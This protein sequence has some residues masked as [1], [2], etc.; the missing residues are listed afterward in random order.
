MGVI[1]AKRLSLIDIC[2]CNTA[3][4]RIKLVPVAISQ[5]GSE[6][7]KLVL[8][9]VSLAKPSVGSVISDAKIVQHM[10][11]TSAFVTNV[12]VIAEENTARMSVPRTTMLMKKFTSVLSVHPSVLVDALAP[13]NPSAKLAVTIEYI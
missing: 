3:W 4:Q 7:R 10:A 1:L 12:S 5:S 6:A 13:W 11:S 2:R 9:C 8:W